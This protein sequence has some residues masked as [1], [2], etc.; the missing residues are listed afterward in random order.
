LAYTDRPFASDVELRQWLTDNIPQVPLEMIRNSFRDYQRRLQICV[1][2]RGR[3][4]ETR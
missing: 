3:S 4:V 2:R 1:D